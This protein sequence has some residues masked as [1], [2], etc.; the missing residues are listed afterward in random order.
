MEDW[1]VPGLIDDEAARAFG[2]AC[3]RWDPRKVSWSNLHEFNA[4]DPAE[5]CP[6]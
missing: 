2:L 4:L 3:L 1:T 5:V 6:S